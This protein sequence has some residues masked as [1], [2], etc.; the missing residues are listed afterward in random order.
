[1]KWSNSFSENA[2]VR[3][4]FSTY[5]IRRKVF[6]FISKK[7][8]HFNTNREITFQHSV[9]EKK[10]LENETYKYPRNPSITDRN[11]NSKVMK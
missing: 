1:M 5:P 4:P 6:Y 11:D 3:T 8:E 2:N 9:G 7:T 10:R